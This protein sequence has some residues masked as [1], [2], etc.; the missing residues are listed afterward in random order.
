M[1]FRPCAALRSAYPKFSHP[2]NAK[3]PMDATLEERTSVRIP[4][5]LKQLSSKALRPS[6]S[7][8][9]ITLF[10]ENANLP[11]VI[12]ELGKAYVLL[13]PPHRI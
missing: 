4:D 2:Q 12:V 3:P 11:T 8:T 5:D 6:L 9:E 10:P 13:W 7:L 1:D